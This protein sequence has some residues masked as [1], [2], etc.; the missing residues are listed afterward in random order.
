MTGQ[1]VGLLMTEFITSL[2]RILAVSADHLALLKERAK[3]KKVLK[4]PK[5]SER[6][7][8]EVQMVADAIDPVLMN[9]KR[10]G[11]SI[12]QL[13]QH[14]CEQSLRR[15]LKKLRLCSIRIWLSSSR[16]IRSHGMHTRC[17]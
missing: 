12:A 3:L 14:L 9:Y 16:Q 15:T 17:K 11:F 10:L 4:L 13:W 6:K 2:M 5:R 1:H 7:T 8:G